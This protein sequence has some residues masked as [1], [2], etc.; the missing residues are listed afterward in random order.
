MISGSVEDALTSK[1]W[2]PP[3]QAE[4]DAKEQAFG[5]KH[6]LK[7]CTG[8]IC[9]AHLFERP[10][11]Y[12]H[13]GD[14]LP[15]LPPGNDHGSLWERNG[16]PVAYVYQPYKDTMK[17]DVLVELEEFCQEYELVH[18]ILEAESFHFPGETTLIM[19]EKAYIT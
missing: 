17:P 10:C 2:G 1:S 11:R 8:T 15:H 18:T 3:S 13:E 19:I 4:W 7:R 5:K 14:N 12:D 6:R 16:R 9:L